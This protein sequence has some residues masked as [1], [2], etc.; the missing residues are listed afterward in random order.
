MLGVGLL[1]GSNVDWGGGCHQAP[2]TALCL[3]T[4]ASSCLGF[5]S[6]VL[7]WTLPNPAPAPYIYHGCP[8]PPGQTSRSLSSMLPQCRRSL[9]ATCGSRDW[10]LVGLSSGS[11]LPAYPPPQHSHKGGRL[12]PPLA[13][14]GMLQGL[15]CKSLWVQ[16]LPPPPVH[17]GC[18]TPG[19][20]GLTSDLHPPASAKMQFQDHIA[21]LRTTL[22]TLSCDVERT[23]RNQTA[24][25]AGRGR[26][27]LGAGRW[28]HQHASRG[29]R[30]GGWQSP[31]PALPPGQGL[32]SGLGQ[33]LC[34]VGTF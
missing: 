17:E 32:S 11:S 23:K 6:P 7:R 22:W 27:V 2:F 33:V 12:P 21:K 18:S 29:G 8:P 34:G 3:Q 5:L 26:G 4:P 28:G 24:G 13:A 19:S 14:A 10:A 1:G 25:Q 15:C 9:W 16:H 30:E 20:R 31:P